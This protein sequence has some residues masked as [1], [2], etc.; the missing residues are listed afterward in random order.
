M[1]ARPRRDGD[2]A[3]AAASLE[4]EDGEAELVYDQNP[5]K[6][7]CP[8]CGL[9][10][11][12]FIEHE[13]S[14]VTYAVSMGL[15]FLLNWAALCVVPVVYPLFKDVVHHCPRCLSVLAT[16]SRVSLPSIRDDVMSFRF[17]TCVIVLAR[18]Y[19]LVLLCLFVVIGGVHS[20]RSSGV[21][22]SV[23]DEVVR[24]TPLDSTW[25]D[26]LKDCGFKSYLGNPIHVTVAFNENF[27]NKTMSWHGAVHHIEP[28]FDFMWFKQK[29]AVFVNMDPPQFPQKRD[30]SDLV[31]LFDDTSEGVGKDVAKFK[32]GSSISFEAT[33]IEVGRRGSPHVG[34]MW[35]VHE[36]PALPPRSEGVVEKMT[37]A[38]GSALH[39]KIDPRENKASGREAAAKPEGGDLEAGSANSAAGQAGDSGKAAAPEDGA[40]APELRP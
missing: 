28:G 8:H 4:D 26:F 14:W 2:A 9:N 25:Q 23:I 6:V 5:V 13:S 15:L 10:I 37:A 7:N 38:L 1:P 19:V 17:G 34:V 33:L 31:L 29:G 20:V 24:S 21:S 40:A 11:I 18:K 39:H 22:H 35:E 30:S 32:R 16:R 27:K 12:T 3:K 36:G